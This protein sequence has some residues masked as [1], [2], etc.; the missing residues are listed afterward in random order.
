MNSHPIYVNTL[1]SALT[2]VGEELL[3]V[4][5]KWQHQIEECEVFKE[6]LS[7]THDQNQQLTQAV[8]RVVHVW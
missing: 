8:R 7:V 1:Q 2:K 4:H 5:E 6:Q 3:V